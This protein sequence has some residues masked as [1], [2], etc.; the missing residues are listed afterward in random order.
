MTDYATAAQ[1]ETEFKGV[2]FSSS[3]QPTSTELSTMITEASAEID[4]RL[5]VKYTTPIT[6]T[7]ALV[8]VRSIC[9][10]L[11]KGRVN[12]I[13]GIKTG[14]DDDKDYTDPS[15]LARDM[16]DKLASGKMKLTDA[17]LAATADG[18]KSYTYTNSIEPNF[19]VEE[20]QW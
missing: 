14:G 16:L 11:L 20:S 4:A 15:K 7:N 17:T 8:V 10:Q 6:G 2:T 5:A 13:R 18:V 12:E 1:V 3:T 9:V 19:D